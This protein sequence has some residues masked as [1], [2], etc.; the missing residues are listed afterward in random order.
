[1]AEAGKKKKRPQGRT[2]SKDAKA[3]PFEIQFIDL[4]YQTPPL[5][6]VSEKSA[7]LVRIELAPGDVLSKSFEDNR[8]AIEIEM[9]IPFRT[10]ANLKS[11]DVRIIV[12]ETDEVAVILERKKVEGQF[13]AD[14]KSSVGDG[15]RLQIQSEAM[16]RMLTRT[17][18]IIEG[19]APAE[20]MDL[21]ENVA[22]LYFLIDGH[23]TFRTATVQATRNV[24]LRLAMLLNRGPGLVH[25]DHPL[26][27]IQGDEAEDLSRHEIIDRNLMAYQL[28]IHYG[29][30]R[31]IARAI[32]AK[33]PTMVDLIRAWKRCE[34][35]EEASMLLNRKIRAIRTKDSNSAAIE[36][37]EGNIIT[38][39]K[40]LSKRIFEQ[41]G[42][43][44]LF[45]K[46]SC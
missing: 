26:L 41:L 40:P 5:K 43:P 35:E 17:A 6:P 23:A 7:Q 13:G 22:L 37:E 28:E 20:A 24:A 46:K 39:N 29:C 4:G 21:P 31:N 32:E 9:G 12:D 2:R 33:Y 38:V 25:G 3:A 27:K 45:S 30:S 19:V 36:L 1:M 42:G 16:Q 44:K 11:G 14:L 15:N 34:D 8:E 18:I 10:D